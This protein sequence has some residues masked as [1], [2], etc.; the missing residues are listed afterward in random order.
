MVLFL[1]ILSCWATTFYVDEEKELF[2][3]EEKKRTQV[4]IFDRNSTRNPMKCTVPL[5]KKKRENRYRRRYQNGA[6]TLRTSAT[7]RFSFC[8][9][10]SDFGVVGDEIMAV[11]LLGNVFI[12]FVFDE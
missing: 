3:T 7:W 12:F 4:A 2:H 10:D 6:K 5:G 11:S 9:Y 8:W 1:P